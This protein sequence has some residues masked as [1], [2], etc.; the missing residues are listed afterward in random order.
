MFIIIIIIIIIIIVYTYVCIYTEKHAPTHARIHTHTDTCDNGKQMLIQT[1]SHDLLLNDSTSQ[2]L[3]VNANY[4]TSFSCEW[5]INYI[6]I[7][8]RQ[9]YRKY[10]FAGQTLK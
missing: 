8:Q 1:T 3:L 10:T 7:D 5:T 9:Q 2:N 4:V 6:N